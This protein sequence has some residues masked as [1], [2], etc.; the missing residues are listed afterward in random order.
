MKGLMSVCETAEFLGITTS[1]LYK[2]VARRR[3]PHKKIGERVL[4]DPGE[5]QEWV[6]IHSVRTVMTGRTASVR[7][8][9]SSA[10][11]VQNRSESPASD[12][13][14]MA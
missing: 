5:I 7:S 8:R 3:I 11:G 9:A 2:Y 10:E 12:S 4:F 1:T 13:S 14:G 6:A